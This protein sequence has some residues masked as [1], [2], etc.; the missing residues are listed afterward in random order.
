MPNNSI[1]DSRM[2]INRITL[3]IMT[4]SRMPFGIMIYQNVD[5]YCYTESHSTLSCSDESNCAV[6]FRVRAVVANV[7]VPY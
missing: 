3:T 1:T 6:V 5:D 4:L 2:T 7:V